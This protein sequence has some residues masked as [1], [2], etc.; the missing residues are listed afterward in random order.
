MSDTNAK[1]T[2]LIVKLM[3]TGVA[4]FA[5]A[6]FLMPPLYNVFCDIT[7][8]NGKTGGRYTPTSETVVDQKRTVKVQFVAKNN[9]SMPWQFKPMIEEIHVHPGEPTLVSFYAKNP[10]GKPMVAQAIPSMVPFDA[11]DYFHK[12][13]CFCFNS[14]PLAAGE[15]A[16]LALQFIVDQDIPEHINTL[17]LAY[18]IF[19]ITEFAGDQYAG[20]FAAAGNPQIK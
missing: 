17:T 3:L 11:T 5:F 8:L 1:N 20:Y 12:T 16:E 6:L 13:E 7:G 15:E 19:D 10:T 18:T 9:E 14:Q 4:M 2:R